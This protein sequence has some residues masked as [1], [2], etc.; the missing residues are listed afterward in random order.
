[1]K[2]ILDLIRHCRRSNCGGISKAGTAG[3]SKHLIT[4]FCMS[5]IIISSIDKPRSNDHVVPSLFSST[6]A[7]LPDSPSGPRTQIAEKTKVIVLG[8]AAVD[9]SARAFNADS[10]SAL[11]STVPGSISV[12]LGGVGRNVAEASHRV[13]P[14]DGS[15]LLLSPIGDDSF[16][17][18]LVKEMETF[19]M[20]TDGLLYQ[21]GQ[22]TAVCNLIMDSKGDLTTGIADMAIAETLSANEVRTRGFTYISN[23]EYV[24]I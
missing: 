23:R 21:K 16:G 15:V 4:R 13:A 12:S 10:N 1:M 6:Q 22:R 11:S 7:S 17:K 2:Q 24:C 5:N 3:E 8:A 19:G 18:M 14:E 20:R 9:V